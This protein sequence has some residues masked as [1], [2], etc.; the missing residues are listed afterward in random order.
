MEGCFENRQQVISIFFVYVIFLIF[1][2]GNSFGTFA[3]NNFTVFFS[4]TPILVSVKS[5][6]LEAITGNILGDGSI[7]G[8]YNDGRAIKNARYSISI[9]ASSEPNIKYLVNGPYKDF[10]PSKLRPYPNITLAQNKEK[11]V[12]QY[13]FDT[14]TSEFFG[15]LH[16]L[17]YRWNPSQSR[18]IKVIPTCISEMF[19]E[20]SLAHW[21]MDDGYFDNYGRTQTLLLCTESF[22]KDEC[23]ILIKSLATLGIVSTL[24]VRNPQQ[25]TYRIRISKKSI[26]FVRD[27]VQDHIHPIFIYKLGLGPS[28]N[29]TISW[30]TLKLQI[31]NKSVL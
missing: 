13:S 2:S 18:Y 22:T 4:L 15:V 25:K 29:F 11:Q 7:R 1:N 10:N 24:K 16:S 28:L 23:L 26:P 5:E 21:I 12:L 9:K 27:I 30:N 17:W 6:I 3:A 8:S 14:K 20:L 19:S 31:L